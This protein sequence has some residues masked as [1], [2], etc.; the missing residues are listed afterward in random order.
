M[1]VEYHI[2]TWLVEVSSSVRFSQGSTLSSTW[3]TTPFVLPGP[4]VVFVLPGLFFLLAHMLVSSVSWDLESLGRV[5]D[6][7]YR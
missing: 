7:A 4:R 3:R 6:Q 5:L 2:K 1:K